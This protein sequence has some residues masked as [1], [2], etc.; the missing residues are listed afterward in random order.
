MGIHGKYVNKKAHG[1]FYS[2]KFGNM[3]MQVKYMNKKTHISF[4]SYKF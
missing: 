2:Y 4:Y 1:S 3:V